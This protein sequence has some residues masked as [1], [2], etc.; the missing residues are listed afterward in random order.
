VADPSTLRR[1]AEPLIQEPRARI[2][3]ALAEVSVHRRNH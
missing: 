2:P 1:R 3:G